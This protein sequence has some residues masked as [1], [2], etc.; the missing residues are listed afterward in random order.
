VRYARPR[1]VERL[2]QN[3]DDIA[4]QLSR[5]H[6]FLIGPLPTLSGSFSSD[7][8]GPDALITLHIRIQMTVR[9]PI[10][11]S[12][13]AVHLEF[14][15]SRTGAQQLTWSGLLFA[16]QQVKL[17]CPVYMHDPPR[18]DQQQTAAGLNA[19]QLCRAIALLIGIGR[20]QLI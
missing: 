12:W 20:F 7:P 11:E 3:F 6:T 14:R 15:M 5:F 9:I 8:A 13:A 10:A 18:V 19:A 1:L 17:L 16:P 4:Q 2:G